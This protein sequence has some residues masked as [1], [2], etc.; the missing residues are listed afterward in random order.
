MLTAFVSDDVIL[1]AQSYGV[2]CILPKPCT[3][4]SIVARVRDISFQ[5]QLPDE[6]WC[7]ENETDNILLQLGFGMGYGNYNCVYYGILVKY[8]AIDSSATKY[9]YPKVAKICGG[10]GERIEKAIRDGIKKAWISGDR[11]V[12]Q[13]Y[14]S[15]DT[16]GE[17]HCPSNEA[18]LSRIAGCLRQRTRLKK[19]YE[20]SR[21]IAK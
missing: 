16:D 19:P 6:Q 2:S 20:L 8:Q 3:L 1:Q 9:I 10:S 5:M 4:G 13:L 17:M 7:I 21:R 18:F 14:F 12:W 15:T 11:R